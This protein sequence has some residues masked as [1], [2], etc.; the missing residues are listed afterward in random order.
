MKT[1]AKFIFEHRHIEE[2]EFQILLDA[3][4]PEEMSAENLKFFCGAVKVTIRGYAECPERPFRVRELRNFLRELGKS[5]R[6]GAAA[7]FCDV[8]SAFFSLYLVNQLDNVIIVER[9]RTNDYFVRCR[10]AELEPVFAEACRGIA[11]YGARA[12]QSKKVVERRKKHFIRE[13][14]TIFKFK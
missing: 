5:W 6:P 10:A 9:D 13:V 7:Y 14:M 4:N 1:T 8:N 11:E 2:C 12:G 3:F